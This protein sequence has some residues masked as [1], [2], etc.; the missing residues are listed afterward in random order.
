A[1]HGQCDFPNRPVQAPARCLTC[2]FPW[3]RV[4]LRLYQPSLLSASARFAVQ[5]RPSPPAAPGRGGGHHNS[6]IKLP[7]PADTIGRIRT[8]YCFRPAARTDIT[9]PCIPHVTAQGGLDVMSWKRLIGMGLAA[10][11]VGATSA[12][13]QEGTQPAAGAPT[14]PP[15]A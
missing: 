8:G 5:G 15:T 10:L 3:Y 11:L 2:F 4:W 6:R 14:P 9:C 7:S 13:A 1:S 12:N